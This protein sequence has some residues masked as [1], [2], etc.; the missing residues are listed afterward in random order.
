MSKTTDINGLKNVIMQR[1]SSDITTVQDVANYEKTTFKGFPAV[2]VT[3]SGNENDFWTNESNQRQFTFI[4]T[5]Y[6]Q[7]GQDLDNDGAKSAAETILGRVVSE[8]IDSFDVYYEFGGNADFMKA[9]PS[10]WGYA[11]VGD[12]WCRTAEI[13]LEV[14]QSYDTQV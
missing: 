3:C 12:G 6:V 14:I 4:I 8:I 2:T 5:I 7:V 11:K 9:I 13:K 10:S 1:I